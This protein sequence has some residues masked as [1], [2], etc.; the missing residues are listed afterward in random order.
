MSFKIQSVEVGESPPI[1]PFLKSNG[2]YMKFGFNRLVVIEE[3]K[4]KNIESERFR[5]RSIKDLDLWYL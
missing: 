5:P 3:K 1:C 4:F 2:R